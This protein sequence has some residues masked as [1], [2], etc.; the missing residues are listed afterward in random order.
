MLTVNLS[1]QAERWPGSDSR[2]KIRGSVMI[3]SA[4]SQCGVIGLASCFVSLL[5]LVPFRRPNTELHNRIGPNKSLNK[6]TKSE[7]F[8]AE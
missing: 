1:E 2:N 8:F 7:F 6:Q 4:L 3:T 5:Y